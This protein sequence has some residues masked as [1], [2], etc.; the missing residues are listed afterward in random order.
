MHNSSKQIG[1]RAGV[2]ECEDEFA[3]GRVEVEQ[4]PIVFDVAAAKS[5]KIVGNRMS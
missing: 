2:G 3:S 5:F 1:V 4:H